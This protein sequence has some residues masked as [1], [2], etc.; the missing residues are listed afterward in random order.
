MIPILILAA[1][2]A[3]RMRGA[4]KLLELVDGTPLLHRQAH[5]ALQV[6]ADV[7]I[8]LP[9][10]PHPRHDV[11]SGLDVRRIDVADAATGM[12]ASLRALFASLDPRS[13]Q[14]MILLADLPDLTARDLR[15]VVAAVDT[16]PGA[17]IWR[18]ATPDGKGGH[19]MVISQDLFARFQALEGDS[20]GQAIL[21]DVADAVHLVPFEDSRAR[22]DLDTPE[23]WAAWRAARATSAD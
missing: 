9:P 1:G 3:S 5:M 6:S 17:L 2:A 11:L 20:G 7:R 18:G 4:D 19:P 22:R 14:A 8:A 23:D 16:H 10:R 12:A 15:Q 13:A 21:A